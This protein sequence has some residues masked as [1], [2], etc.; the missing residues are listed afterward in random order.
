[1]KKDNLEVYEIVK[2]PSML[3]LTLREIKADKFALVGAIIIILMLGAI[4]IAAPIIT[5]DAATLVNIHNRFRPPSWV[6]GGAPGYWLGTDHGGRNMLHLLVVA[7]RNSII[8]GLGVA[9]L[10]IIIGFVVGIF[11]GYFGGHIDNVVMRIVDTWGMVPQLMFIIA[12]TEVLDRTLINMIF[13]LVAFS[14]IGRARLIRSMTLQQRN[15]DYVAASKTMGTRNIVIMFR[16]IVPNLFPVIAPDIV[17]TVAVTIGVE[18][19]LSLIGFGLPHST[20]SLGTIIN[21]SLVLINL[22]QRWWMWFPAI[23]IVFIL[24]LCINFVGQALQ[25][26]ADPRQRLV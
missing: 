13:L 7:S 22:Q 15:L 2:V 25:R 18:T 24:S 9:A 4:I 12:M 14:W 21:N 19:G 11:S 10:S 26:V 17:L 3:T 5:T 6:E 23:L 16:E 20:P 8:I 1:M